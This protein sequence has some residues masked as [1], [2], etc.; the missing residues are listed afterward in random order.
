MVGDGEH[1]IGFSDKISQFGYLCDRFFLSEAR[2]NLHKYF[3]MIDWIDVI[4]EK[5][6]LLFL[7]ILKG[8]FFEKY[9][10]VKVISKNRDD[11]GN[12]LKYEI[13]FEFLFNGEKERSNLILKIEVDWIAERRRQRVQIDSVSFRGGEITD[14]K[15]RIEL[16]GNGIFDINLSLPDKSKKVYF[17]FEDGG[18]Q[19][20]KLIFHWS[21]HDLKEW[22][23]RLR[24]S[25][26]KAAKILGV[27]RSTY[28]NYLNQRVIPKSVALACI[29][30]ETAWEVNEKE[31]FFSPGMFADLSIFMQGPEVE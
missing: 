3:L 20:E 7:E 25:N 26:E 16:D 17:I 12:V 23:Y 10:G 13:G 19:D 27:G 8:N 29:A 21:A 4:E 15:M 5:F 22:Q 14:Y 18:E 11:C 30:L 31:R 2:G 9:W 24:I 28:V 1:V 6:N